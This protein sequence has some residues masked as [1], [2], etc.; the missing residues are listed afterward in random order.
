MTLTAIPELS[1]A[2]N[3]RWHIKNDAMQRW[4]P[5][6]KAEAGDIDILDVIGA[7]IFGDGVTATGIKAT[8]DS[9]KGEDVVVNINSPGGDVFEGV[10]IYNMLRMHEGKVRVNVLGVA[11][12]AASIIAMAADELAVPESGFLMIHNAWTLALGNKND[13]RSMADDLDRIDS[14]MVGVYAART[15]LAPGEIA[16]MMDAETFIVGGD[17]LEMGFSD[18][19]LEPE[20]VAKDRG[21]NGPKMKA[22]R[23]NELALRAYAPEM[24]RSERKK[25]MDSVKPGA[26]EDLVDEVATQDAGLWDALA[27]LARA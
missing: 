3:L 15:G 9:R 17:A 26:D 8:L 2:D 21:K 20:T 1:V 5:E 10:A 27:S 14:A 4:E 11:A 13:M 6:I 7:D 18:L 22:G 25:T 24:S 23:I 12:S 19:I 16:S